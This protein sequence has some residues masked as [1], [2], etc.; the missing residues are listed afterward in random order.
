MTLWY[1]PD[2]V[3][4]H[5]RGRYSVGL[6]EEVRRALTYQEPHVIY[7]W[8]YRQG[9]TDGTVCLF[10]LASGAFPAGCGPRV[11]RLLQR[12]RVPYHVQDDRPAPPWSEPRCP[13]LDGV[14]LD[15]DQVRA[16]EQLLQA[17]RGCAILPTAWGKTL[18]AAAIL[19]QSAPARGV[20]LVNRRGL[21]SQ[22]ASRLRAYLREP[23]GWL[24]AGSRETRRRVTVATVQ[25]LA[26]H[27]RWYERAFLPEQRVVIVD[28]CHTIAWSALRVLQRVSAPARFGLSATIREAPRRLFIEAC[29]GPVVLEHSVQD[30]LGTGR[31]AVPTVRMYRV[32]GLI[33]ETGNF[34][35]AYEVG[36]VR[37]R[38]RNALIVQL[39]REAVAQQ[40][41]TILLVW[42]LAHGH[43]LQQAL[44]EEG[45]TAPFLSGTT[46]VEV[47]D[48]A[49]QQFEEGQCPLLIVSTIFDFGH[50]VPSA[51]Q[52][53]LAAAMRS[54]LR[55]IQRFGRGLR[56]KP[57]G[58]NR[59]DVID[60][61][62]LGHPMLRRHADER[63][64]TYARKGF[65]PT[66]HDP[67][68]WP[69]GS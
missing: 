16:V 57:S 27:L 67:P 60:F 42:S 51:S 12:Q 48:R 49:K 9:L 2:C 34:E 54:P 29:L 3:T 1:A 40:R 4:A 24:G 38:Q 6:A 53:I 7:T 63:R 36:I 46:P 28:E 69:S 62:D 31:A 43:L 30:L 66:L 8:A 65:P 58:D 47:I 10:D 21:L 44:A 61:Y 45:V 22:T 15:P 32:G 14:V 11:E 64:Q 26:A 18:L 33:P 19:K 50:D 20:V 56:R 39:A 59:V 17:G 23:V 68:L 35:V 13:A 37:N 25:S 5:L 52:L 55:T 41:R